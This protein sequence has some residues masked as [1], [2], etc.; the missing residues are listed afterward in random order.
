MPIHANREM[1]EEKPGSATHGMVAGGN[2]SMFMAMGG[3]L[4]GN[5]QDRHGDICGAPQEWIDW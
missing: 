1:H 3:G 5:V 4:D 2:C